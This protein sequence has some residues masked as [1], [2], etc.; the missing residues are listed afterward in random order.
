MLFFP[1]ELSSTKGQTLTMQLEPIV[2]ANLA[3][4]VN[5][6]LKRD[7]VEAQ[8][9]QFAL[10]TNLHVVRNLSANNKESTFVQS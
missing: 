9:E 7:N 8:P 1:V 4:T 3:D 6:S 5:K 10:S 2:Y